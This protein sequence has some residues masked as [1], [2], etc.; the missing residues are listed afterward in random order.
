MFVFTMLV[1]GTR[2]TMDWTLGAGPVVFCTLIDTPWS[3]TLLSLAGRSNL[4]QQESSVAYT[5]YY[6]NHT[7]CLVW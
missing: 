5:P 4:I 2:R 7:H 3:L 1:V 6:T